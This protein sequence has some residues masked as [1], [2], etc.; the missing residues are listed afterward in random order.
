VYVQFTFKHGTKFSTLQYAVCLAIVDF[1]VVG[2]LNFYIS[3]ISLFTYDVVFRV[4]VSQPC[5]VSTSP[6]Y[7]FNSLLF[8]QLSLCHCVIIGL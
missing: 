3:I 5:A 2:V 8:L 4:T 7:V 1:S 6:M